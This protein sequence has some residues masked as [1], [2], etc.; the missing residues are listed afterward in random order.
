MPDETNS[1]GS[2]Y[3]IRLTKSVEDLRSNAKWTLLAFGAIGTTL[4]AGSQ[5]SNLGKFGLSDPRL[6]VAVG[7][8]ILAMAAATF[9][10]WS[11]LKVANTGYV[12]FYHLEPGDAA[13][14]ERNAALLEGFGTVQR[15]RQA[16]DKAIS[17]RHAI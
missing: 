9:A 2:K 15:L 6:L 17:D 1:T 7:C 10:V 3:D 14:V 11:A 4:L 13:Y 8:A 12:E 5:L 16:Y